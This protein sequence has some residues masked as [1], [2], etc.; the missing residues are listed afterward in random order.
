MARSEQPDVYQVYFG[1]KWPT[2]EAGRTVLIRPS[3][4]GWNDFGF[5]THVDLRIVAPTSEVTAATG[6]LGFLPEEEAD[7]VDASHLRR[8]LSSAG[9]EFIAAEKV[10]GRFFTML[11]Q[12]DE[13]RRLVD[14]LGVEELRECLLSINDVVAFNEYRSSAEWLGQA[15]SSDVFGMSFI[16]SSESYFAFKNAGPLLRGAAYETFDL[17]S[18]SLA[19]ELP[20]DGASTPMAFHFDHEGPLPKRIAVIIGKNGVGKSQTL[21]HIARAALRDSRTLRDANG[22]R[23]LFNRLLAF[24]PTNEAEQVFPVERRAAQVWY[25]RYTLNRARRAKRNRYVTDLIVQVA[26]SDQRIGRDK[27][28]KIFLDAIAAIEDW[29]TIAVPVRSG[30]RYLPL[31]ELGGSGEQRSLQTYAE[32]D[33]TRPPR[34]HLESGDYELS[35]GEISFLTFAAQVCLDVE[36]G[37]LLLVD[38][39]ET[40][41]HPQ[42][43]SS[44]IALL[45]HLLRTTG[46]VAILATHSVFVVR[47]AFRKQVTVLRRSPDGEV[48]VD[49][50]T[51]RTFGADPGAISYFVFGEDSP[52]ELAREVKSNLLASHASWES[53]Y[54]TYRDELSMEFLNELRTTAE[55]ADTPE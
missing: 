37:S 41:L 53:L 40:H 6:F 20:R 24:A 16:R 34:R 28:W 2:V 9:E 25:R 12:M 35:S 15:L 23:F 10:P 11:R 8:L 30:R 36:N 33:V 1:L 26:R 4:D 52:S 5:R 38:E 29:E 42:L 13:Y 54:D 44:F 50:P 22:E 27:R 32:V 46:S 47:E 43:I 48:V 31:G 17:S 7:A 45:N 55:D 3:R 39:P 51:L 21:G 49:R 19:T 14:A 18:T